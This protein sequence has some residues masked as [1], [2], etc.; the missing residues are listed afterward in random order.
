[1]PT[2]LT[3]WPQDKPLRASVNNFGYGGA[4]AHVILE[5]APN[6]PPLN[7][8][9][10]NT[11]GDNST[12]HVY[13]VSSKDSTATQRISKR[14]AAYIRQST[15][16]GKEPTP[17]DLAY[18]LAERRSRFPHALAVKARSLEELV[19]RLEDPKLKATRAT[20][21]PR[22]GFVF[23]G[24]GAQWYAMGRELITAYPIFG[25]AI[26]QAD[27]MLREYGATWSLNG[28]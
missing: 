9:R 22:I 2:T 4:N 28:T 5:G 24:Q 23:N 26:Q 7:G 15:L 6:L 13:I 17:A 1:M 12:S 19:E 8:Y 3:P 25:S 14:L 20:R 10:N 16:D 11:S 21:N 27:Q 18:T